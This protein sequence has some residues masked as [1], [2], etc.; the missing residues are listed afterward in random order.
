MDFL[1]DYIL[2]A[3]QSGADY[4]TDRR[5]VYTKLVAMIS[6]NAEAEGL[7]KLNK[8]ETDGCK[9]W[10][11]LKLH[12]ADQ[13]IFAL[14]I[15]EAAKNILD[16]LVY[17]GMRPP[18]MYWTKFEQKVNT[19]FV[20]YVKVEKRIVHSDIMKLTHLMTK[21]KCDSLSA[22]TVLPLPRRLLTTLPR[23]LPTTLLQTT[24]RWLT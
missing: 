10:K 13:G 20:I 12:Y 2:N 15:K 3:P 21:V 7:I 24:S 19:A 18:Q 14:E 17:T 23:R 9:D 11:H 22:V 6:T 4:L 16:N 8:T 5:A 1:Y